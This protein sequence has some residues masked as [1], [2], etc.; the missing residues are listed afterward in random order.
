METREKLALRALKELPATMRIGPY[1]TQIEIGGTMEATG[2]H[3]TYDECRNVL[4]MSCNQPSVQQAVDT[5]IH[6]ITHGIYRVACLQAGDDEERVVSVL[7]TGWL[8]VY[9]DNPW[10]IKWI[11]KW[12]K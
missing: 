12:T 10:L 2:F 3:G 11:G 4:M 7:A 8:Q 1:T 5:L 9:K 6:E